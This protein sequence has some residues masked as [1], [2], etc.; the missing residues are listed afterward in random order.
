MGTPDIDSGLWQCYQLYEVCGPMRS[1]LLLYMLLLVV[2]ICT[3]QYVISCHLYVYVPSLCFLST[4]CLLSCLF[5]MWI[6]MLILIN[7]VDRT[8]PM[9]LQSAN[10]EV[11][12]LV[13]KQYKSLVTIN[14]FSLIVIL[15]FAR[16]LFCQCVVCQCVAL[17]E[18]LYWL[19]QFK[20]K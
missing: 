19:P 15:L 18:C 11:E 20:N 6:P 7:C 14:C 13:Q 1:S 8:W 16:M 9:G 17:W 3:V 12:L 5:Y 2:I 10:Q 4:V